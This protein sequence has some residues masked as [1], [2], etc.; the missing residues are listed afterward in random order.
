[1]K[2]YFIAAALLVSTMGT[3]QQR[4][5]AQ[6]PGARAGMAGMPSMA[7]LG[8]A[9]QAPKAFKDVIT[10]KAISQKGLFTVHKVEDKYYF[11]IPNSLM[12]RQILAVTRYVKV[13][14]VGGGLLYVAEAQVFHAEFYGGL[15]LPFRL[16]D[17]RMRIGAY[18]V[19]TDQG[20]PDIPGFRLKLGVDFYDSYRGSW[21]Y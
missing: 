21:N 19:F 3:A 5:T 15:E 10:S 12:G 11:E 1:M 8:G 18:R 4:D 6:A 14:A 17:Q 16:W 9:R 13:P 7:G 2:N 20:N